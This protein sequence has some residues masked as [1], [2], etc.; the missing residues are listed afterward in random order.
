MTT[1]TTTDPDM[2]EAVG[3]TC[4]MLRA[5]AA[6]LASLDPEDLRRSHRLA[7][8]LSEVLDALGELHQTDPAQPDPFTAGFLEGWKWPPGDNPAEFKG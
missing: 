7:L 3:K 5:R 6:L 8:A 2:L 1:T 4:D